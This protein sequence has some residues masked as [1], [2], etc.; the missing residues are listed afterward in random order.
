MSPK[1]ISGLYAVTPQSADTQWLYERVFAA[2]SGGARVVQYRNKTDDPTLRRTQA[3]ELLK[4]CRDRD[5]L[6]LIND[7][8][9]LALDVNAD[10]VHVGRD[11]AS[12]ALA[13]AILGAGKIIG[14]SCYDSLPLALNA[15][16]AGAD[17]VAF[18][19][20]YPSSVKPSAARPTIAFLRDARDRIAVRIV[21]IGGIDADNAL[22]LLEAGADAIAV[23]SAL[24][25]SAD[26]LLAARALS[27]VFIRRSTQHVERHR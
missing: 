11:D 15:Q 16:D 17:Y 14:A 8:V 25:Q 1:T 10:G 6:F 2:V 21:A 19:S 13:R 4:L 27:N 18:G 3:H 5:A 12:V 23:V 26:T 24:F 22:P 9:E 20:F 7:D